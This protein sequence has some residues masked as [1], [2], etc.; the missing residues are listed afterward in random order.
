MPIFKQHIWPHTPLVALLLV[1]LASHGSLLL[2]DSLIVDGWW[3]NEWLSKHDWKSNQYFAISVGLFFQQYFYAFLMLFPDPNIAGKILTFLSLYLTSIIA[4]CL[5][6]KTKFFSRAEAFGI[7]AFIVTI[8]AVR[9][10]GNTIPVF[11]YSGCLLLFL[12]SC[13]VFLRSQ[14]T[15]VLLRSCLRFLAIS[16]F[17]VSFTL[18]SLL[19]FFLGFVVGLFILDT[20]RADRYCWNFCSRWAVRHLDFLIL[21]FAFWA[22]RRTFFPGIGVNMS[23]AEPKLLRLN[24]IS[25]LLYQLFANELPRV[26][27]KPLSVVFYAPVMGLLIIGT[28]ALG[29]SLLT[30]LQLRRMPRQIGNQLLPLFL[31]ALLLLFLAVIPYWLTGVPMQADGFESRSAILLPIPIALFLVALGRL[32]H[33]SNSSKNPMRGTLF[34]VILFQLAFCVVNA[35][36]YLDWQLIG[37]KDKAVIADLKK[38]E[39]IHEF[40]MIKVED[41]FLIQPVYEQSW[42]R[43]PFIVGSATGNYDRHAYGSRHYGGSFFFPTAEDLIN[44]IKIDAANPPW[45]TKL[46]QDAI[47]SGPRAVLRVQPG[48]F[49]AGFQKLSDQL[50]PLPAGAFHLTRTDQAK[51]ISNY[52][53]LKATDSD[54]LDEFLHSLVR[55]DL[56]PSQ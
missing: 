23:Y 22:W 17:F 29:A 9:V 31:F 39:N 20:E 12:F 49:F 46:Q 37:I 47:L 24:D 52:F 25:H 11:M 44:T 10:Y 19:T 7:A 53:W 3:M 42:N 55:L 2:S 51:L 41:S 6:G 34:L 5:F 43:W 32:Y 27:V 8:P 26:I 15:G 16:G 54:Q 18:G 45:R 33:R 40:S 28:A 14:N 48:T 21:P 50:D 56:V 35:K 1:T 30:R 4:F 36:T 13:F 38:L